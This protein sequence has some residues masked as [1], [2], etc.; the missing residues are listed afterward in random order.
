MFWIQNST[1]SNAF[2]PDQLHFEC[3]EWR[4]DIIRMF[5]VETKKLFY[6]FMYKYG[7]YQMVYVL[8]RYFGMGGGSLKLTWLPSLVTYFDQ[9]SREMQFRGRG[10]IQGPLIFWV[11]YE[12][13]QNFSTK[14]FRTNRIFFQNIREY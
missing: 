2:G 5:G 9:I 1:L 12:T 7:I 10:Q 4:F 11:K 3:L 13:L 14:K 6:G 8:R